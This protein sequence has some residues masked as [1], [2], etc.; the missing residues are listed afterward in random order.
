[1]QIYAAKLLII[2][3][4]V[5]RFPLQ[6]D[7]ALMIIN[8]FV[9]NTIWRWDML[10]RYRMSYISVHHKRKYQFPFSI[11]D[12]D[13]KNSF[14]PLLYLVQTDVLISPHDKFNTSI[15]HSETN[16]RKNQHTGLNENT[17]PFILLKQ[18]VMDFVIL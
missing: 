4:A 1:M 2:W 7:Q 12:S 14:I 16:V 17:L 15:F 13:S 6:N 18:T 9:F 3:N 5:K 8:I 10:F 11:S